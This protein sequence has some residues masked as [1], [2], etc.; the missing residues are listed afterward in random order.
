MDITLPRAPRPVAQS[1]TGLG[2]RVSIR[3]IDRADAPSLS[4]LYHSL[5]PAA[6]RARF[7]GACGDVAL[8][9]IVQQLAAAP[10]FVAVLNT[11]GPS[12]GTVVGHAVVLPDG[13]RSAEVALV[14]GEGQRG[15]GIGTALMRTAAG[16]AR[17]LGLERLTATMYADNLPMRQLL[18]GV[19]ARKARW[20]IDCGVAEG[21]ALIA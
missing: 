5:S 12:D 17:Q 11:P 10:G 15:R 16:S 3:P 21:S 19:G 8:D 18:D 9:G 1:A 2:G 14:V 4:E 7:L 6:R 20:T 13:S